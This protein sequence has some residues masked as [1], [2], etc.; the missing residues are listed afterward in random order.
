MSDLNKIQNGEYSSLRKNEASR[1]AANDIIRKGGIDQSYD[2]AG[3]IRNSH[4]TF[5]KIP[6]DL[7]DNLEADALKIQK[8]KMN[9]TDM[10]QE[11]LRTPQ[12]VNHYLMKQNQLNSQNYPQSVAN[13]DTL[14]QANSTY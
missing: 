7:Q 13:Q 14:T 5:S 1:W 10:E 2:M 4:G 6:P 8:M 9:L 11:R 3:G 12:E